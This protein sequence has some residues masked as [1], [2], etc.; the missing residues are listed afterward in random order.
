MED[1]RRMMEAK[2]L[3]TKRRIEKLAS[4]YDYGQLESAVP[5]DGK[6]DVFVSHSSRRSLSG[7]FF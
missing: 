2:E 6:Y 7:R 3:L 1:G 4:E 5:A